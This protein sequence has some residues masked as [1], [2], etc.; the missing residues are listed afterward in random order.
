[1]SKPAGG[2]LA[3][4]VGL[5][6]RNFG[7]WFLPV[8]AGAYAVYWLTVPEGGALFGAEQPRTLSESACA[9]IPARAS[10]RSRSCC[11]LS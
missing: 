8:A 9:C 6:A 1:M 3:H 2:T 7:R 5:T 11:R 4:Q 10:A